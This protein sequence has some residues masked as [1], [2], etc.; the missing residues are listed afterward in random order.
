[1][2]GQRR[3]YPNRG[4]SRGGGGNWGNRSSKPANYR[5]QID[6]G[7]RGFFFTVEGT[8]N[9][10]PAVREVYNLFDACK[11]IESDKI[12]PEKSDDKDA[13][14]ELA[15]MCAE[16]SEESGGPSGSN[17]RLRQVNFYLN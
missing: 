9:E 1:M 4:G 3:N 13:A 2:S 6:F 7:S 8:A 5:T 15:A 10:K 12:V 11:T 14:D 17:Q 16:V